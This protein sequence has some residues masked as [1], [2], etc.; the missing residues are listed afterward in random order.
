MDL[1]ALQPGDRVR[2]SD[3]AVVQVLNRTEDGR[4]VLVRY[5]EDPENPSAVGTEDLCHEE[6]LSEVIEIDA[7]PDQ[8]PGA[9]SP[10]NGDST[11]GA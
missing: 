10:N 4:W 9:E 2:T 5:L 7:A 8:L 1:W 3:G 11:N 6:E